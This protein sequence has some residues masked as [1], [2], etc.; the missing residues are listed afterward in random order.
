MREHGDFLLVQLPLQLIPLVGN[1]ARLVSRLQSVFGGAFGLLQL[2][3]QRFHPALGF[4]EFCSQL[5]Y[6]L[7][8]AELSFLCVHD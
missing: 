7:Y 2:A 8:L 5:L 3:A 4:I 6:G 1:Y